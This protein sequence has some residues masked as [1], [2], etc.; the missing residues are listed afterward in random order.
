MLLLYCSLYINSHKDDIAVRAQPQSQIKQDLS[1]SL[2]PCIMGN[3]LAT[4]SFLISISS[5]MRTDNPKYKKKIIIIKISKY[6]DTLILS[7]VILFVVI[8]IYM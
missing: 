5:F 4:V 8:G 3:I 1:I 7:L 2:L 6:F